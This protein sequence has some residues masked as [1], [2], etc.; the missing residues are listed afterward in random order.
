M[1]K[2]MN[3]SIYAMTVGLLALSM[4]IPKFAMAEHKAFV[5]GSLQ[6]IEQQYAGESFLL[7]L[8]ELS[9]FPCHEEMELLAKLKTK[10]PEANVVLVSTDPVSKSAEVTA[11][12]DQHGLKNIDSWLFA[13]ANIEKLR[14]SI[15]PEWF[16]ELPRNYIYDIDGSRFGFSGKLTQE[17]LDEWVGGM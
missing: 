3:K 9:C 8:W 17:L 2:M 11:M 13:D 15:D 5:A 10:H 1:K 14:Y 12:L 6:Q 16:G 7:V 4:L